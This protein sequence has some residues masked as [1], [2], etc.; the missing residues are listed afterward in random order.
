MS[1]STTLQRRWKI[2]CLSDLVLLNATFQN[3]T[4][5]ELKFELSQSEPTAAKFSKM[6]A[7]KRCSE[8]TAQMLEKKN[9]QGAHTRSELK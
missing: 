7:D 3:F 4:S 8:I 6:R 9:V 2:A 5:V 1:T